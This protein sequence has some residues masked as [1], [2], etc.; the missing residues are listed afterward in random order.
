MQGAAL[1]GISFV[2]KSTTIITIKHKDGKIENY[3][4]IVEFPFDSTRKRMSLIVKHSETNKYYLMCKGADS[5]MIPRL[6]LDSNF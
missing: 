5:I 4:N 6:K 1:V 3:E 2:G